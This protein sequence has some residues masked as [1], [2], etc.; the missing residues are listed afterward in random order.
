MGYNE[1]ILFILGVNSDNIS[2]QIRDKLSENDDLYEMYMKCRYLAK[3]F[4]IYDQ[5]NVNTRSQL[6]SYYDFTFEYETEIIE[7]IKY[8]IE[9]EIRREE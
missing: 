4:D 5:R 9:F 2:R 7:Y 3:Q 1:Y 8:D 6:D